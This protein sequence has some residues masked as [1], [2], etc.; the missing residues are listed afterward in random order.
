MTDTTLDYRPSA[1]HTKSHFQCRV[2]S[3]T[4][5]LA[6]RKGAA[7]VDGVGRMKQQVM[8]SETVLTKRL[9][10]TRTAKP[11]LCI[12][13]PVFNEEGAIKPFLDA[14]APV[15]DTT[16]T[17]WSVLF[18][19][20]G[21]HDLTLVELLEEATVNDHVNVINFARNFGKEAAL[22]A[23]IDAASADI[24][25]FMDVD[26]QDPPDLIAKF[27]AKWRDGFDVVYG[28]RECRQS[29]SLLKKWTADRFYRVFNSLSTVKIPSNVGDYRLIDRRVVDALRQLKERNRFMKGLFAWVG[30]PAAA[31]RFERAPRTVGET[32]FGFRRLWN[33]ALDGIFGFST[34][35]LKTWTYCGLTVAL[36]ALIYALIILVRTMVFGIDLPGYASTMVVVLILGAAQIIS[37]GIIGEYIARLTIEA[38]QRPNYII[39]G[40]YGIGGR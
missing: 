5:N 28:V 32:K 21:S 4:Q 19:N 16:E 34:L 33:F 17:E 35:P 20:D 2:E 25:V 9:A 38:K 12:I 29:D 3:A 6:A 27:V 11:T 23:G 30:F 18:I 37:L 7:H 40:T 22:T 26:L 10:A 36:I 39:E 15:L 31:V 13:V 14:V 8:T 1:P 24:I